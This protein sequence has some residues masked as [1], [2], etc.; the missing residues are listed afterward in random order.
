MKFLL[1]AEVQYKQCTVFTWV[2]DKFYVCAHVHVGVWE[3][4]DDPVYVVRFL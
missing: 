4:C 3:I 1:I 2:E